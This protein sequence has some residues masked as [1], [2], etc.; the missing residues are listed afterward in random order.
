MDLVKA[1]NDNFLYDGKERLVEILT[2][3]ET[4]LVIQEIL[5]FFCVHLFL[6]KFCFPYV[7]KS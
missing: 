2:P 3:L 4:Y 7:W 1:C 6:G 5:N